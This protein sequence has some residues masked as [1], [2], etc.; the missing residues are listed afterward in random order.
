VNFDLEYF[1]GGGGE[2]LKAKAK[3]LEE[4]R[5]KNG[6]DEPIMKWTVG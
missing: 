3:E 5:A 4:L 1:M 2:K 6:K